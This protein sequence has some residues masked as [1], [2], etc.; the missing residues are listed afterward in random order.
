MKRSNDGELSRDAQ[1][2]TKKIIDNS[3][4]SEI[5]ETML[6]LS[7]I[8]LESRI[9]QEYMNKYNEFKNDTLGLVVWGNHLY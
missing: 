6:R 5:L 3:G 2:E 4:F 8:M 7:N 9:D 1:C